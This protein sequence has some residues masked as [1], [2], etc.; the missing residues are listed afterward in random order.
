MHC[1]HC[2]NALAPGARFCNAC[3]TPATAQAARISLARPTVVTI[4]AVLHFIG[5]PFMLIA[6]AA[7]LT[8]ASGTQ[9]A[10]RGTPVIL[11]V[12]FLILGA[13]SILTGIGL[14]K[15]RD[16]G[17]TLQIVLACVGLLGL[18]LGTI[19]SILLLVYFT[20]PHV[21]VLFSGKRFDQLT[22][23]ETEALAAAG[24]GGGASVLVVVLVVVLLIG[25]MGVLAAI[26]VPNLLTAMNRA[27]QKRTIADMLGVV[28]S[29]EQYRQT[30]DRLPESMEVPLDGWGNRMRYAS[31]GTNYWLVSAGKDGRFEETM[32]SHY[33]PGT[34]T[35][36]DDD[37]VLQNGELRR[38]PGAL[39][40]VRP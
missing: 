11:G 37:I 28:H 21:K 26:A 18:P 19:I 5:G 16:W 23:Q 14:W 9:S 20:R 17:R 33:Q 35:S 34:T 29:V 1:Q 27:K 3:G 31:D 7:M 4:V 22:P 39:N 2:G 6:A 36:F 30:N 8:T 13:T 15:K 25:F 32:L 10:E 12:L 40:G 38:G 24:G